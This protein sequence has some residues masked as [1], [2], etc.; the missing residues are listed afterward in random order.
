MQMKIIP[1]EYD[2]EL[3]IKQHKVA[4]TSDMLAQR[5]RVRAALRLQPG[6]RVLEVGSGNGLLA[7]ELA[8]DVGARGHVSAVDVSTSMV[9]MAGELCRKL[10]NVDTTTADAISLPFKDTSFDVATSVQCLC[11]V[12]DVPAAL[13]EIYRVLRP[14]GRFVILDTDW[15]TLVWNSSRPD[16]MDRVMN[17]YKSIYANAQLPRTLSGLLNSAGFD[18]HSREQFAI[19]NW[20]NE[21]ESYSGH[22]VEFTRAVAGSVISSSLLDEWEDSIRAVAQAGSYFFSLNRYIFSGVRSD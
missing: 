22:Q 3:A 2:R 15:D 20:S 21:P 11:F 9:A 1:L 6:E 19:L 10:E 12:S 16:L 18:I 8:Y 17:V 7:S 4:M 14:G 13:S 5:A